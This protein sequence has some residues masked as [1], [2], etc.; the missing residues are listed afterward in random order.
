MQNNARYSVLKLNF[1]LSSW[2]KL[3]LKTISKGQDL[4]LGPYRNQA[5]YTQFH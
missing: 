3:R 2:L 1:N 4:I 5:R